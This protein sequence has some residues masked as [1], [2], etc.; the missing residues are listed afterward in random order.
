MPNF[1]QEKVDKIRKL[2]I[3]SMFAASDDLMELFALKGGNALNYIYHLNQRSSIDIDISMENS[4]EDLDL[5]LDEVESVLRN[6]FERTFKENN[7]KA[8]DIKLEKKP[9]K[10]DSDKEG[11]WGG[12]QLSFKALELDKWQELEEKDSTTTNDMS[13]QAIPFNREFKRKFTVD[14]SRHEYVKDKELTLLDDYYIYV[15]SPIMIVLEKLRAICQQT[16]EYTEIIETHKP[17]GRAQDFFDIYIILESFPEID[18]TSQK[19]ISELKEVF[20]IKKVPLS[21]LNKLENYRE[22]HR[23]SFTAV[24]DTVFK[25]DQLKDYDFYFDYVLEKIE[26]INE[27]L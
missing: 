10:M 1:D 9:Q 4:F 19:T 22:F 6:S 16:E 15:Y 26:L 7:L 21:I 17:R 11:F 2:T 27:N 5:K 18:L 24:I 13:R 14:I 12:Y 23:D 20:R 3:I 25:S 8:F